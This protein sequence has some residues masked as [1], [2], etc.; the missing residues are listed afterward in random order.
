[1]DFKY[2]DYFGSTP[3]TGYE[4]LLYDAMCGD[5][6]LFHRADS[7]EA[8]WSLVTPILDAW[9]ARRPDDFPNYAAMTWGP[10]AAVE[11]MA[12]EGRSWRRP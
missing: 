12:R 9:A 8:G 1:M 11:L 7:V 6:T 3:S 4:T 10:D 5:Q 2:A